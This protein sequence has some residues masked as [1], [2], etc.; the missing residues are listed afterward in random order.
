M[1]NSTVT[2]AR[3]QVCETTYLGPGGSE[4]TYVILDLGNKDYYGNVQIRSIGDFPTIQTANTVCTAMN[5]EDPTGL[6]PA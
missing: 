2:L 5:N 4:Y 6:F 3:F 1:A